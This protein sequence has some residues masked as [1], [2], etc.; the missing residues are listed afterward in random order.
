MDGD[1]DLDLVAGYVNDQTNRLCLN[2][3]TA[4]PFNGVTGSDLTTDAHSTYSVA[5][6][7]V[8][9]DGD[10]DHVAGNLDQTNRL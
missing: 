8:D 7:D 6:G 2:S 3:G 10:L 5:L 1:G 4:A 9:G